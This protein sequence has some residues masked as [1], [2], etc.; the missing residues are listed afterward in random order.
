MLM[1]EAEYEATGSSSYLSASK[2]K[3]FNGTDWIFFGTS[4]GCSRGSA[5]V[6]TVQENL[7]YD[8]DYSTGAYM[9]GGVFKY[10]ASDCS[11]IFEQN[12]F[13]ATYDLLDV[14]FTV[15]NE[16]GRPI[17][18]AVVTLTRQSD[19]ISYDSETTDLSGQ[20]L[21]NKLNS[22]NWFI[23]TSVADGYTNFSGLVNIIDNSYTVTMVDNGGDGIS[24][25]S[26]I[27]SNVSLITSP[28][29]NPVD[30][31][32]NFSI[33]INSS[34]SQLNIFGITTTF[35]GTDYQVNS[36][37]SSGGLLDLEVNLSGHE[38]ETILINYYFQKINMSVYTQSRYFIIGVPGNSSTSIVALN[39]A[40]NGEFDS[41]AKSFLLMLAIILI[42]AIFSA[43]GVPGTVIAL[44]T[45]PLLITSA[46]FGWT[47]SVITGMS[48]LIVIGIV[49]VKEKVGL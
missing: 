2:P 49:I 45:L 11:N 6:P 47:D 28:T 32:T 29:N 26:G 43:V 48:I 31:P 5:S 37:A 17:E 18:G 14:V 19:N 10:W 4:S 30:E 12:I 41:I 42:V 22:N 7:L 36:S 1:I 8:G 33:N 39:D 46:I 9:S 35:N 3:Y 27:F 13:W 38:G 34:D 16:F 20:V 15:K 40:Y 44:M 24:Y 25:Y 23:L 21:V